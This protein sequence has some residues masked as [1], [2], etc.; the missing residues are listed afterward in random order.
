MGV[1]Q[2]LLRHSQISVL[3]FLEYESYLYFLRV[4][5][6]PPSMMSVSQGARGGKRGGK[7][8]FKEI[9]FPQKPSVYL[10]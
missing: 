1:P 9:E 7:I 8:L 5:A 6:R 10:S 2:W 3:P 4:A